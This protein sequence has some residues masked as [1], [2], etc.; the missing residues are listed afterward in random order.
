[1]KKIILAGFLL[2][3]VLHGSAQEKRTTKQILIDTLCQCITQKAKE[4]GAEKSDPQAV[5]ME[6]FM[7]EGMELMMKY[8]EEQNISMT[9]Q[10]AVEKL[11]QQIGMELAMK[12][13]AVLKMAMEAAK[14]NPGMITEPPP[15][16][17]MEGVDTTAVVAVPDI[18]ADEVEL[19]GTITSVSTTT[20][21]ASLQLKQ[22]NGVTKKIYVV[23]EY[24]AGEEK[25][26]NP[27][28]LSGKKVNLSC[29]K[30]KVYVPAKKKFEELEILTAVYPE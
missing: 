21:P 30:E 3:A 7:S 26:S 17:V 23:S 18:A 8:A 2:A 14:E 24:Y 11:G 15:P 13:P 22:K 9:D 5:M 1:M 12:C 28:G 10:K 16:M 25:M 20:F 6:C 19:E 29:R 4:A 27:T